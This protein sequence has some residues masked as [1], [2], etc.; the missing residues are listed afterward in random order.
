MKR[1]RKSSPFIT[2]LV[3]CYNEADAITP[4]LEETIAHLNENKLKAEFLFVNDGSTDATLTILK[5]KKAEKLPI[6]IIDLSRNFGKEASMS[7]GLMHAKGEVVI[8]MD[9][10]LQDPPSLI[11]QMVQ[12][13]QEGFDVVLAKR[14]DRSSDGLLKRVTASCFYSL[15]KRVCDHSIPPQVGDFRLMDRRVVDAI[16]QLPERQRFMKGIFSWVGF[17]TTTILFDRPPRTVGETKF[18]FWKLWNFAL[19]G[20]TSFSSFPLRLWSY[21][22]GIIVCFAFI[23]ALWIIFKTLAFGI[24]VPG[25]AS[26]MTVILFLGGIQLMSLGMIGEYVGRIYMETKQR[27]LYII[28][29][30]LE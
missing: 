3:P 7:A 4:F 12:A 23:Y 18:S 2:I 26:L 14:K 27:P 17:S 8:P 19:E 10:D 22:G 16:N 15:M 11:I 6:R 28:D 25:Y 21:L 29:E 24:D 9:C 30:V 20:I 1:S 5:E 13:W